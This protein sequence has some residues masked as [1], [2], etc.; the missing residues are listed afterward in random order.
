G[1]AG[2]ELVVD[3]Q[4]PHVPIRDVA[5]EF[6]NVDAPVAER[7]ALLVGFGDLR[8]ECDDA[9]E[10][11]HKVRHSRSS[12]SFSGAGWQLTGGRV[13]CRAAGRRAVVSLRAL[14]NLASPEV[15]SPGPVRLCRPLRPGRCRGS[16]GGP[17]SG[18]EMI[19]PRGANVARRGHWSA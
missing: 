13:A 11:R 12:V 15:G 7:A 16:P 5:D 8:L 3:E 19:A 14:F 2:G 9:L 1:Q 4:P 17:A 6:L 10:P 18:C